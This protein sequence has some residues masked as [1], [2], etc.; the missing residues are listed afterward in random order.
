MIISGFPVIQEGPISNE[1]KIDSQSIVLHEAIHA[2]GGLKN[3]FAVNKILSDKKGAFINKQ[4]F[5]EFLT[6]NQFPTA[7]ESPP[8]EKV[9]EMKKKIEQ[10]YGRSGDSE[11]Y[12]SLS[13]LLNYLFS[14][15]NSIFDSDRTN[16]VYMVSST[17]FMMKII[18]SQFFPS[19]E[20]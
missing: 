19:Y 7:Q 1:L 9:T 14:C 20:L 3:Y 16:T 15:Q 11:T 2:N 5:I 13:S 10:D 12:F 18:V 4:A 6:N 17:Y 8:F